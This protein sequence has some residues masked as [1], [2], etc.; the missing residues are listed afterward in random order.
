MSES[1]WRR[2]AVVEKATLGCGRDTRFLH[3]RQTTRGRIDGGRMLTDDEVGAYCCGEDTAAA[4]GGGTRYEVPS[5]K[6]ARER[7]RLKF[8][9]LTKAS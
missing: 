9:P 6:R 8:N 7:V 5:R 3:S 4:C 2:G 1:G